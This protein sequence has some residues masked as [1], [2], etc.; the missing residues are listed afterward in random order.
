MRRRKG[1]PAISNP[2]YYS[3]I[4]SDQLR[5]SLGPR[6]SDMPPDAYE[7]HRR[8]VKAQLRRRRHRALRWPLI[9]LTAAAALAL[10]IV[11]LQHFAS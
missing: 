6:T 3:G 9:V 11:A 5:R 4:P 2:D 8:G 10:T 7:A 1:R